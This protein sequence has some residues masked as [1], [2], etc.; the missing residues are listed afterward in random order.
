MKTCVVSGGAGFI[1]SH[2]IKSLLGEYNVIC[3]DNVSTGSKNNLEGVEEIKFIQADLKEDVSVE[4]DVDYI[5]H[6]AS[7]AS[8]IDFPKYPVDILLSNSLGTLNMLRL[9]KEKN[10]RLLL[11]STSEVYGDP[12]EHPQ[13]EDYRGNVN[14]LGVR[15]CYDEG[16]RFAEALCMAF[17]REEGVDVRIARIFNT[18]GPYMRKDDGRVMP[19][20]INQALEGRPLTVYGDGKQT[21]CFC[22]VDDMVD[23]LKKLMFTEGVNGAVNVGSEKEIT[24]LE[25]AEII[26]R[27]TSSS[28]EIVFKELPE[29]DPV[30]RRPDTGKAKDALGWEVRTPLEEGLRKTIEFFRRK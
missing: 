13:K 10:A 30:K 23:G 19:N 15:G 1:G 24:V 16:K 25:L 26:K 7:R 21:R 18:Y 20:F 22:Y 28:S 8:P 3:I 2:L 17:H 14:T 6:L 27:L 4:G 11:A 29:N 9:A 12:K 5:F